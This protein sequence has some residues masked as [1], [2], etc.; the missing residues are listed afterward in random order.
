MVGIVV[1]VC[2]C[3]LEE[4]L[5][6]GEGVIQEASENKRCLSLLI[7]GGYKPLRLEDD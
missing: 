5:L 3:V 2:V 1:C 7:E 4:W 6:A